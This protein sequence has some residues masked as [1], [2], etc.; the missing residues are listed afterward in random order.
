MKPYVYKC[1]HKETNEFYFG[2]RSQNKVPSSEDLGIK[3]FTSS[4][5]VRPRFSEFDFEIIKEF[6]SKVEAHAYEQ[7]LI[8]EN[9]NN[10]LILNKSLFPKI[11]SIGSEKQ[12]IKA[13]ERMLTN[14]PMKQDHLREAARNRMIGS[15]ASEET[16]RKMSQTRKGK[17]IPALSRPGETNPAAKHY[18]LISPENEIFHVIGNRK[19]FCKEHN[20]GLDSIIAVLKGIKESYKGWTGYEVKSI[21]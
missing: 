3:Y 12:R 21:P 6:D 9:W 14:N 19:K 11:K 18:V 2:Y 8:R 15:K 1:I 20:L 4:K 17:R 7:E 13:R 16:K 10:P 5:Y